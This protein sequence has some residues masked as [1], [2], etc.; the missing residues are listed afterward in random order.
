[1]PLEDL[2]PKQEALQQ[3]LVDARRLIESVTIRSD[4]VRDR[5][6]TALKVLERADALYSI[7]ND[8]QRATLNL[9]AFDGLY[10]DVDDDGQPRITESALNPEFAGLIELAR[11]LEQW[12][13]AM[14]GN[15]CSPKMYAGRRLYTRAGR[16]AQ[17]VRTASEGAVRRDLTG[18]TALGGS[19]LIHLA[20]RVGQSANPDPCP[21]PRA[22]LRDCPAL[23]PALALT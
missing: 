11:N 10:L 1:M 20:G 7:C 2:R 21:P 22:R 6:K 5:L 15:A 19:N 23:K 12:H 16:G 18:V 8:D 17:L 3:E 9:A 14:A 4:G 13:P